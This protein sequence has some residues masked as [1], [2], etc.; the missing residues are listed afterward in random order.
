[1]IPRTLQ[2]ALFLTGLLW[3]IAARIAAIRAA[4]GFAQALHMLDWQPLFR[5]AAFLFLLLAGFAALSWIATRT[6]DVRTVNALPKR[7]TA[8]QEWRQGAALGWALLLL[9]VLPMIAAGDLHPEFS[10]TGHDFLL[11]LE[12]L[13]ALLV[14]SL[15]VEI[16]YRGFLFRQLIGATNEGVAAVLLSGIFAFASSFGSYGS[17]AGARSV[18]VT[19]FAGLLFSMAYLR[20]HGLWLGWGLRFGWS[21]MTAVVFGLPLSGVTESASVVTTNAFGAGWLTG[22]NYGPDG[23]LWTLAVLA[24]G[25]GVLYALTKDYAWHY[26]YAPIVSGGYAMDVAPPAAHTAMEAVAAKPVLVQIAAITPAG[27]STLPEA[28]AAIRAR[29][30]GERVEDL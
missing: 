3:S 18:E 16:A 20:T 11:L 2:F 21:V 6:G 1:M 7:A 26:T 12:S 9:A 28:E 8:E 17:Y 19:F 14:G 15:A 25:A 13:A 10:A 30:A 27:A 4:R 29:E 5:E 24:V 22:G 23:S